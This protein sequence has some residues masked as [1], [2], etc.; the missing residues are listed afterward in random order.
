MTCL[1]PTCLF[2]ARYTPCNILA[3]CLA[4]II[5]GTVVFHTTILGQ[6]PFERNVAPL[7]K[8]P[9][10]WDCT[11]GGRIGQNQFDS[12]GVQRGV[13]LALEVLKHCPTCRKLFG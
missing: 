8:R 4:A 3:R 9:E 11:A 13:A 7:V 5:L 2:P 10:K 12:S 1:P 6:K